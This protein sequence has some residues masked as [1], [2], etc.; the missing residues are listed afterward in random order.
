MAKTSTTRTVYS[1]TKSPSISPITSIGT[2]A[3]PAHKTHLTP[4]FSN[5][6]QTVTYVWTHPSTIDNTSVSW[7]NRSSDR[8][9]CYHSTKPQNK[10]SI[11]CFPTELKNYNSL[12]NPESSREWTL[13]F[14]TKT[15]TFG[16]ETLKTCLLLRS[17]NWTNTSPSKIRFRKSR[18]LEGMKPTD[19]KLRRRNP[20]TCLLLRSLSWTNTIPSP[21]GIRKSGKL[22][23]MNPWQST[24]TKN[25]H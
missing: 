17:L 19:N 6:T 24:Q 14:Q 22:K 16:E 5:A 20:K 9:S 21:I 4:H 23:G 25:C 2:P 15:I 12:T 10:T 13:G 11:L 7:Q 1:S 3:L 8:Y 18:K